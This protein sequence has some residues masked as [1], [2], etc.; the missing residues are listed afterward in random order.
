VFF[1]GLIIFWVNI[2][3]GGMLEGGTPRSL[4]LFSPSIFHASIAIVADL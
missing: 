4:R 1:F 2:G 3:G